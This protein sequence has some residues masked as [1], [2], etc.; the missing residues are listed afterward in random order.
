MSSVSSREPLSVASA[1]QQLRALAEALPLAPAVAHA[2]AAGRRR[3]LES[4][5]YAE[6]LAAFA[7]RRAPRFRGV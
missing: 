7:E 6:G 1:K 3:A 2:L 4:E 5:D